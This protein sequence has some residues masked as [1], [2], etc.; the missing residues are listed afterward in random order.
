MSI[1]SVESAISQVRSEIS[2]IQSEINRLNNEIT[3]I[4]ISASAATTKLINT[5][6]DVENCMVNSRDALTY[7]NA[8]IDRTRIIQL[9]LRELYLIFKEME[10]ANKNIYQL[11]NR[12]YFE[13]GTYSKVRKIVRGFMDNLNFDMVSNETIYKTLEKQHLQTPDYW[14]TCALLAVMF[15]KED[16]KEKA[17]QAISEAI[18]LNDK[19]TYIFFMLFNIKIKR[20]KPALKWFECYKQCEKIGKDNDTFLMLLS[21][22][23]V[24]IN[25]EEALDESTA[26]FVNYVKEQV[27]KD[28]DMVNG[29]SLIDIITNYFSRLDVAE[30]MNY[31]NIRRYIPRA[32]YMA[33]SL[34]KA[35]NNQAILEF[36]E[37]KN[38]VHRDEINRYADKYIDEMIDVPSEPE[39]EIREQIEYNEMIIAAVDELKAT[40]EKSH[41]SVQEFRDYAMTKVKEKVEHDN[42]V[43]NT[44]LE[45]VNWVFVKNNIY[46]NSLTNWNMFALINDYVKAGY[47]AYTSSYRKM[48]QSSYDVVIND[49]SFT[50]RFKNIDTDINIKNRFMEQKLANR[51]KTVKN[52]G[53]ILMFIFGGLSVIGGI[54]L[55]FVLQTPVSPFLGYVLLA[56]GLI[57]ILCGVVNL[58]SNASKRK[59]IIKNTEDERIKL[60]G[61]IKDLYDEMK[62]YNQEYDNADKISNTIVDKLST[63]W[64]STED[65]TVEESATS[66]E[67]KVA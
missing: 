28:K 11:N 19:M 33:E 7:A 14:L 1:S 31:P 27:T 18:K 39:R 47:D 60:D 36:I 55:A 24:R 44:D 22:I 61:I 20:F 62:Q 17:E 41:L 54:L 48:H 30:A 15:W 3:A 45:L 21:A 46:V 5:R 32:P 42:S 12:L 40:D 63:I 10:T 53:A 57:L 66:E 35:K 67:I 29:D 59:K 38:K 8:A 2:E 16:N 23:D 13:F 49:F 64:A 52:I 65:S 43:M 6:N 26:A 56:V 58:I 34:S 50:T 9:D 4:G 37:D 25:N 51:L